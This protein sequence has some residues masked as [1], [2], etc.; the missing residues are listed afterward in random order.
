MNKGYDREKALHAIDI[1]VKRCV[2]VPTMTQ[3]FNAKKVFIGGEY[4]FAL[5]NE[6]FYCGWRGPGK[7][8][9]IADEN[10]KY[11]LKIGADACA[12]FG[13]ITASEK[14]MV[15]AHVDELERERLRT[16]HWHGLI[17]SA[18]MV[19]AT[20]A[21]EAVPERYH[22]FYDAEQ[23]RVDGYRRSLPWMFES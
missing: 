21:R 23:Q 13:L 2:A 15:R 3:A 22:T 14:V 20:L 5:L 6:N 11:H 4:T 1:I 17:T 19:G 10:D 18:F 16:A 8:F 7:L 12:A 9:R